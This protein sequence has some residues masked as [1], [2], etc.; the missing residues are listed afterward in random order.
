MH[1][2]FIIYG[3]PVA[4]AR[5]RVTRYGTYTPQKTVDYEKLVKFSYLKEY[6]G[7]KPIETATEIHLK[8]Y[9]PIPK[10]TPKYKK[11]YKVKEETPHIKRPDFD[12]IIKSVVDGLNGLA[13]KD[14]NLLY[15]GSWEKLYSDNPRVEVSIKTK[16]C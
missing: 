8:I 16:E 15:K 13:Y 11:K 12:N 14:D 10:S 3:D 9:M 4:K 7:A 2:E 5:P 1:R 6:R